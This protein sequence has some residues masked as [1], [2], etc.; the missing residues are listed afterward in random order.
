MV[1]SPHEALQFV[2]SGAVCTP[3]AL[4]VAAR[5]ELAD[6]KPTH[7]RTITSR[8]EASASGEGW[9]A[10]ATGQDASTASSTSKLSGT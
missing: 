3:P 7:T 10:H 6:F 8:V 9:L 1:R 5:V 2:E 4:A